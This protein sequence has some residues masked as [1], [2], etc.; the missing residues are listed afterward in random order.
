M[1]TILQSSSSTNHMLQFSEQNIMSYIQ[2]Q[3]YSV[4]IKF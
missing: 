4:L 1:L 2:Q 3:Q